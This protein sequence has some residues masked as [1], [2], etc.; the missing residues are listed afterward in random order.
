[1]VV[2]N[3]H[4]VAFVLVPMSLVMLGAGVMTAAGAQIESRKS[5]WWGTPVSVYLAISF[6]YMVLR[7]IPDVPLLHGGLLLLFIANFWA[8][9]M[10]SVAALVRVEKKFRE[11][12]PSRAELEAGVP[13][14]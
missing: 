11:S 6:G 14:H 1:M 5:L 9:A 13:G 4:I 10:L 8:S 7:G 12:R 2:G 3:F